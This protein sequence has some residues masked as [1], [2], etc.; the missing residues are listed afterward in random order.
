MKILV[1]ILCFFTKSSLAIVAS[2]LI[3][4]KNVLLN[5]E[6]FEHNL[7]HLRAWQ[8][9]KLNNQ[10]EVSML[11]SNDTGSEHNILSYN[12]HYHQNSMICHNSN[13][14]H[15]FDILDQ[16]AAQLPIEIGFNSAINK[17]NRDLKRRGYSFIVEELKVWKLKEHNHGHGEDVWT[18]V[19]HIVKNVLQTTYIQ[20]HTHNRETNYSCHYSH[21][22]VYEPRF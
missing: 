9:K 8:A 3:I 15:S 6:S 1:I 10:N 5:E 20:C 17:L 13:H 4:A 11:A 7:E 16:T 18:K 19:V 22:P 12:C 21:R 2:D 14:H